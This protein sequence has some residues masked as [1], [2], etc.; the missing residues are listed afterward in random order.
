MRGKRMAAI[1]VGAVAAVL[2]QATGDPL[3]AEVVLSLPSVQAKASDRISVPLNISGTA[4]P[5]ILSMDISVLYESTWLRFVEVRQGG[6]VSAGGAM[7]QAN[8]VAAGS[9][10]SRVAITL[11]G[12]KPLGEGKLL[13]L[14]FQV[15]AGA[16][17][18]GRTGLRFGADTQANRGLPVLVTQA[19]SVEVQAAAAPAPPPVVVTVPPAPPSQPASGQTPSTPASPPATVQAPT[20]PSS[21]PPTVQTPTI[22]PSRPGDFDGNLKVD[23]EDFFLFTDTFGHRQGERLFSADC[24]MNQDGQIGFPDFFIFADFFGREY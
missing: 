4:V 2:L 6:V 24:D 20:L 16:P 7:L 15:D 13:D 19:G 8:A 5:G 11:A 3:L 17:G 22:R 21:P 12:T 14:V 23:M 18:G 10:S 9:A 1:A